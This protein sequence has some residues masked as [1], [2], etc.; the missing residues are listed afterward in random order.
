[1]DDF[2]TDGTRD[3]L[4]EQIEGRDGILV[5]NQDRNRGKGAAFRTGIART[6]GG[7][8]LIQDAD[9]EYDPHEYTKLLAPIQSG[10]ADVVFGSRFVGG[11]SKR[12]LFLWHSVGNRLLTTMSNNF[13]NLNLS[14]HGDM[15]QRF[16]QGSDPRHPHRR[17]P[18]RVRTRSHVQGGALGCR[19]YE[20]G[21]SC[22]GCG[23]SRGGGG[24]GGRRQRI[25]KDPENS[26]RTGILSRKRP[27]ADIMPMS[28]SGVEGCSQSK[29]VTS[30]SSKP[31]RRNAVERRQ[32]MKAVSSGEICHIHLCKM[33]IRRSA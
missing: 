13:T 32:R 4:K 30:T 19:N 31:V 9:L 12:V 2:S 24:Q 25:S 27:T 23:K 26:R 10:K 6:T 8:V 28:R 18:V 22:S 3:I 11:E 29:G 7:I 14:E 1:V 17:G 33:G 20:V 5:H 21:I 16:S 15:L